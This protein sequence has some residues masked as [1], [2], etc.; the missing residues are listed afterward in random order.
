MSA[1]AVLIGAPGAGKTRTGKRVARA[2][3]VAHIDTDKRFVAEHG[4]IAAFFEAYGEPEFRRIEREIVAAALEEDAIVS[5]GGGAVLD[6]ATQS[7]LEGLPVVQLTC[8]V[9]AIRERIEREPGEAAKRPLLVDG[10]VEAWTRLVEA[11]RPVYD[12]LATVTFDTSHRTFD[13]VAEE[14]VDWIRTR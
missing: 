10:G 5:L 11:R 13:S 3:G 4:P 8:T 7:L 1:R 6:P 9:A 2:L 14:V 12:R